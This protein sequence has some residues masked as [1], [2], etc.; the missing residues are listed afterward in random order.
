M[1]ISH[2]YNDH[3]LY[4]RRY[5]SAV[6]E[7]VANLTLLYALGVF[8]ANYYNLN[9]PNLT[10]ASLL[11]SFIL[12]ILFKNGGSPTLAYMSSATLGVMSA[13][14]IGYTYYLD[15]RVVIIA[16]TATSIIFI[17]ISHISF[18][19]ASNAYLN[20]GATLASLLNLTIFLS[21]ATI[22]FNIDIFATTRLYIS[23]IVFMFYIMHDLQKTIQKAY[24]M[25]DNVYLSHTDDQEVMHDALNL[26]LD[27]INI[28]QILLSL[29][30][31]KKLKKRE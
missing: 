6:F 16:A 30:S 1:N 21:L 17:S 29:L 22:F 19:S 15:P 12:L 9:S 23:L 7:T 18:Y 31:K 26:L 13:P 10:I 27:C 5:V 4:V 24:Y 28:F 25:M 11:E 8:S 3:P 2:S 20:M 14:L